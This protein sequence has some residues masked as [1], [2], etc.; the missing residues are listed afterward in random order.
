MSEE[1]VIDLGLGASLDR[2]MQ[3]EFI[4]KIKTIILG[5]ALANFSI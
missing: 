1:T 5:L 4:M 3:A 2:F